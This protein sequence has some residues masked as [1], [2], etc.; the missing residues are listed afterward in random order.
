MIKITNGKEIIE[1][2]NGAYESVF[3]KQGYHEI[4]SFKEEKEETVDNSYEEVIEEEPE[5]DEMDNEIDEVVEEI[6]TIKMKPISQ[7]NKHEIKKVAKYYNVDI[8][9]T[10]SANEARELIK[11]F[12]IK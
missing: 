10:Q 1:V 12:V 8:S 4:G 7:W 3:K 11:P 9:N 5:E 2:T 6:E